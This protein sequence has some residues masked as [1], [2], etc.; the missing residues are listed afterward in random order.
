MVVRKG[1]CGTRRTGK[2]WALVGR[3]MSSSQARQAV[4]YPV[5]G[6]DEQGFLTDPDGVLSLLWWCV[7]ELN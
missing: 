1:G 6:V 2:S 4:L 5:T 7:V 3:S